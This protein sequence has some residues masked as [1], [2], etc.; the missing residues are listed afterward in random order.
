WRRWLASP[1]APSAPARPAGPRSVLYR[2]AAWRHPVL[3]RRRSVW[4][5][6]MHCPRWPI[7]SRRG[8]LLPR[9]VA[10][11]VPMQ[12]MQA[13]EWT[14]SLCSLWRRIEE[15]GFIP[16][17]APGFAARL[18]RDKGW[19][20][21]FSRG[22]VAEYRRFCF[23]AVASPTPVTPSEVVDEVWHLHLLHSCEYWDVW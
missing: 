22:A 10:D 19:P 12:Q 1:V 5:D 23:L 2:S 21:V 20:A 14:P 6:Q 11:P 18:A 17:H 7:S 16:G 8:N 4:L 15:H 9:P 3:S 13:A